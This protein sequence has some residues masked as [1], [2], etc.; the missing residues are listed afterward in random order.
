MQKWESIANPFV[1]DAPSLSRVGGAWK[2]IDPTK[3]QKSHARK[4]KM[5]AFILVGLAMNVVLILPEL[6]VSG[7]GCAH[8]RAPCDQKV[9]PVFATTLSLAIFNV[10]ASLA[11]IIIDCFREDDEKKDST[12]KRIVGVLVFMHVAVFVYAC[13][14]VFRTSDERCDPLLWHMGLGYVVSVAVHAVVLLCCVCGL[15]MCMQYNK[16]VRSTAGS[17]L[18][19]SVK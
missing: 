13:L 3:L 8:H 1:G 6:V 18:L 17:G 10:L 7:I 11:Y 15:G 2:L 19:S 5:N 4:Q 12:L 14:V 16:S 9:G